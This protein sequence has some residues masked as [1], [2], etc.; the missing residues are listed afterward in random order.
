M[1]PPPPPPTTIVKSCMKHTFKYFTFGYLGETN[2]AEV[3]QR[4]GN[5][6]MLRKTETVSIN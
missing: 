5:E 2:L 4:S 3:R 1:A 6:T